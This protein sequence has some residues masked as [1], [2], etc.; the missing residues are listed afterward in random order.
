MDV[1]FLG[2]GAMGSVMA[3]NLVQAGHHVRAWNR[4]GLPG[5]A[6][7]VVAV[8]TPADAFR[9]DVVFTMLSDDFAIREVLL[10]PGVLWT[11]RPGVVH[12]VMSTI[13]VE[14]AD[15]LSAQHAEAGV[16]Y[17]SA[18]VFGRPEVA[19]AGQLNIMVAG[20]ALA[21]QKARPLL[22]VLG[23]QIWVLG[24][25][26]KQ[27][28]AAKIA[29]NM[30]ITMAIQAM[31]EAVV[32]TGANGLSADVFFDLI[33]HTLFAGR[34]YETY[35]KKI[36]DGDFEAGF[37]MRLGLKDLGLA[38]AAAQASGKRLPLLVAVHAQMAEAV[39]AGMGDKDW[40]AI[41]DHTLHQQP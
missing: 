19:Q 22:D 17:V 11:A 25:D 15:E 37:R 32:L 8:S 5:E 9:A 29:G 6:A 26:P 2:L 18:P 20:E 10:G 28:T 40:S 35:S 36:L 41:A 34:S 31:A 21:V 4:S 38:A 39:Q 27:A 14:L 13:S 1:G 30:M 7:G 33:L 3:R 16:G 23:K 12:V 24:A